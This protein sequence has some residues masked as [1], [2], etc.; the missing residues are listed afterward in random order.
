MY[1]IDSLVSSLQNLTVESN[2][3]HDENMTLHQENMV[4]VILWDLVAGTGAELIIC[5]SYT[6]DIGSLQHKKKS[7][8]TSAYAVV[9]M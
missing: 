2:K 5:S 4:S 9:D 8:H 6:T 3:L 1:Y 7:G